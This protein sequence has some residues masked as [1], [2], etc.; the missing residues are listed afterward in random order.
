MALEEYARKRSFRKTPE[1]PPEPA[2]TPGN[3]FCVQRHH[4]RRLHYDFRVEVGGTLKSWAVPQGPSLDP[5]HKRLAVMVE[6]HPLG[7]GGFEGNIPAG[8]YG[9]GSVMLWDSGAWEPAADRTAEDMLERGDFKFRLRGRKLNGEFALV[10]MK[11]RGKGPGASAG[12]S[13]EWLLIKKRDAFAS[14]GWDIENHAVSVLTGRTQE[15]IARD[16]PARAEAAASVDPGEVAGAVAAP[17]PAAIAPMLA[18][19]A[20]K[21]PA[22]EDWIF[23]IKWDGVRALC[24]LDDSG[25]R[26]LTRNGNVMTRQYPE[27]SVL[28]HFVAAR[29]AILDGEIA[30]LDEAGRPSFARI[31]PRIMASDANAIAQLARSRPV[32]L[33][34][35]DVLYLN[36]YDL[37]GATLAERKRL[38]RAI[39]RPGANVRISDHF[40]GVAAELYEAARAQGLEG[41]VAK[42]LGSRYQPRRSR[43][44]LK[45]K[46]SHDGDFVICG[47]TEGERDYFGALAL[48][49]Y[50][51]GE[52]KF[53]GCVGTGFDNKQIEQLYRLLEPL[54]TDV[55]PFAEK[56]AI[57]Q[58]VHWVRPEKV[59]T[60]KY[61][62]WTEDQRL[63]APV[64]LG[65]RPDKDPRECERHPAPAPAAPVVDT[66]RPTL[67]DGRRTETTLAIDGRRL[68]FRHLDKLYYPRDG[69]LKRDVLNYYDAIAGLILPHLKDRPLSLRRYPDGIDQEGFFQKDASTGFPDW[70]RTT[71]LV[72]G[73]EEKQYAVCDDRPSLIYLTNLGCIDHNPWMSRAGS[74]ENPDFILID[75]DPQGCGYEKIVEAAL[76]VRRILD[77]L[78]LAGYPKTTGGDGMHI[79][80]PLEPVYSYEQARAFAE[81]VARL[82]ASERPDLFT[83]PRAVSRRET[84][85]VYF[86]YLQ[87]MRGKTISAPYVLRAHDRAPVATP[88][89]WGE[90]T[91]SLRPEQFHLRNAVE[92]FARVGDLFAG[93]LT[94]LQR[95]EPAM[96]RL[97]S[98]V[99]G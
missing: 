18:E 72:E 89:D 58:K 59:C 78:G 68:A 4:A 69:Y 19:I 2:S 23:E 47:Y 35:F 64:Y 40:A 36:G 50:D 38:L 88:L 86:D 80:I 99:R 79:Y 82:A 74:L 91:P 85:R 8:N 27:L 46:I 29:S 97:E 53:A 65:L 22:G 77:S 84:G 48:G 66:S 43:E 67:F 10:R 54:T 13:N 17:M 30:A 15:E 94:N 5:A 75:L 93:V 71:T 9:A 41:L 28:P 31:Q 60:V 44:W 87:V 92:R 45:I 96:A 62:S 16:M 11:S 81:I 56:P 98:M 39:V 14:P 76:V 42:R 7:Y 3:S 95:L 90:L 57:P 83:A 51:R 34:L 25:L 33:F 61:H 21:P 26:L 73:G 1:P 37:R 6:D 70:L 55:C 32:T 63:R 20:D 24:F 52:L 49:I 12:K